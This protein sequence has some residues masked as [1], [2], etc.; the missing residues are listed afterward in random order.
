MFHEGEELAI[1]AAPIVCT[2]LRFGILLLLM[3]S[4]FDIQ[5][6]FTRDP[7]NVYKYYD[8]I[9]RPSRYPPWPGF[10]GVAFG[11]M[12]LLTYHLRWDTYTGM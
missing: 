6:L 9:L 10:F 12:P 5:Y 4:I 11:I 3:D 7:T 8:T 1:C 2:I